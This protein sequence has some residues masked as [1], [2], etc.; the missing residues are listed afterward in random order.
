MTGP[1][2]KE[3]LFGDVSMVSKVGSITSTLASTAAAVPRSHSTTLYVQQASVMTAIRSVGGSGTGFSGGGGG[4]AGNIIT[5]DA[6]DFYDGQAYSSADSVYVGNESDDPTDDTAKSFGFTLAS[7]DYSVTDVYL[8]VVQ[9]GSTIAKAS[10]FLTGPDTAVTIKYTMLPPSTRATSPKGIITIIDTNNILTSGYDTTALYFEVLWMQTDGSSGTSYSRSFAFV[11][12]ADLIA[13]AVPTTLLAQ[14]ANTDPVRPESYMH[15]KSTVATTVSKATTTT[16]STA[17]ALSTSVS[18]SLTGPTESSSSG[19]SGLSK[20]AIAGIAVST[21]AALA[22]IATAIFIF[23]R[24]RLKRKSTKSAYNAALLTSPVE[25]YRGA[26]QTPSLNRPNAD[27]ASVTMDN[28]GGK[29]ALVS[30]AGATA[31][32]FTVTDRETGEPGTPHRS[33]TPYADDILP[34]AS[35]GGPPAVTPPEN[36]VAP[37]APTMRGQ[38]AA[39]IEEHMTAEDVA[40]LEAEERELDADIENAIRNRAAA[41]GRRS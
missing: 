15:I 37:T 23:L 19:S 17:V 22:I 35:A 38:V 21:I 34:V 40:R 24:R 10:S 6:T 13:S 39:L 16:S 9:N 8:S 30:G 28:L 20:G 5:F 2:L 7:T 11:N 29:S 41:A 3:R 1:V 31:G 32:H 4:T 18:A 14:F 25:T 33:L 36:S 27:I 12:P 26:G